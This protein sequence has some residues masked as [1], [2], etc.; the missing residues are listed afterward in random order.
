MPVETQRQLSYQVGAWGDDASRGNLGVAVEIQTHA[1]DSYP[2]VFDYFW[3]GNNLADASFV[4]FGYGIEPGYYCLNGASIGGKFTC[5]SSSEQILVSDARWQW[6]YWPNREGHDFYYQ[7]GPAGSAGAN[8]TW[9]DYKILASSGNSLTFEFDGTIVM[10]LNVNAQVSSDPAF[11]VAEKVVT[12]SSLVGNLGPVEFANLSYLVVNGWRSADS[13]VSFG[14][15]NQSPVCGENLYG[16]SSTSQN[17]TIAGSGVK[18]PASGSLLWT[19]GYSVLAVHVHQNARFQV[20]FLSEQRTYQGNALVSVP[21]GMYAYVTIPTPSVRTVG[22]L[23]LI[24][25]YDRF[26]GWGGD[27]HSNNL[28]IRILMDA[29][30]QITAV[31]ATQLQTPVLVLVTLGGFAAVVLIARYQ[32]KKLPRVKDAAMTFGPS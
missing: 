29:N 5:L 9:H 14:N 6:Q 30:K 7:I 8:S 31:W 1:Y 26:I 21:K 3:V 24:G 10:T 16:I 32:R 20:S 18:R 23:D 19:S 28:T 11:I 4:Q 13:L 17:L 15:C 22:P 2:G 27:A 12:S 25:A